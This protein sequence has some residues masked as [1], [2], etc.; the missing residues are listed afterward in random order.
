MYLLAFATLLIGIIGIY[1][2]VV[3]VQ[4][5]RMAGHQQGIAPAMLTWHAAAVSMAQSIVQTNPSYSTPCSLTNA[6]T[7]PARCLSPLKGWGGTAI[8]TYGTVTNASNVPN[9]IYNVGVGHNICVNL[10][11]TCTA[12]SGSDCTACSANYDTSDYQ[13]Y[14]I[15]YQTNNQ[16]Y[17]ITYIPPPVISAA[18]PAPG[19]ITAIPSGIQLSMT[20]G[21]VMR[22]LKNTNFVNYAY[23]Y[24]TSNGATTVV[25]ADGNCTSGAVCTYTLPASFN[26]M[27]LN[28]GVAIIGV[29]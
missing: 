6:L 17:V 11:S 9:L 29:P 1:T 16:N 2:Q 15:L 21:D 26:S 28:G 23:G 25:N 5:A 22:Q 7:T 24:I 18:N 3:A 8:E 27:G 19:Y 14:S 4:T 20:T 10:P 12:V 13:F